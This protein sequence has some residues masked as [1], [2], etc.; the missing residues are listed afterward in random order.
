LQ[1][2][3]GRCRSFLLQAPDNASNGRIRQRPKGENISAKEEKVQG[4]KCDMD[5]VAI[6]YLNLIVLLYKISLLKNFHEIFGL[7]L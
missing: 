4:S 7:G 6:I 3:L 1:G 2:T 5:V